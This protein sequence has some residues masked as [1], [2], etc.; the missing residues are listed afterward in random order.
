M[1]FIDIKKE[2][3]IALL[4]KGMTSKQLVSDLNEKYGRSPHVPSLSKKLKNNTIRFE[5]VQEILDIL[6]YRIYIDKK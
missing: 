2:I 6:G 3:K 4:N 1:D 5:E